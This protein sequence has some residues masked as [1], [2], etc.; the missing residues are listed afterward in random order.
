[1]NDEIA[2]LWRIKFPEILNS[3]TP[4]DDLAA[5]LKAFPA[6][7]PVFLNLA[8]EIS[9]GP[10]PFHSGSVLKH[11]AR[12][13]NETAGDPRAVWLA[14]CHDAGKLL[15]PTAMLPHHYGHETRGARLIPVWSRA[16]GMA[17]EWEKA[18]VFASLWHMR[19]GRFPVLR[20][21]K[22]YRLLAVLDSCSWRQ[23]FW[24]AVNADTRSPMGEYAGECAK[25]IAAWRKAGLSPEKQTELLAKLTASSR[26]LKKRDPA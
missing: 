8:A 5:F 11:V 12:C 26:T 17:P 23:A 20:P 14:F 1:M 2:A 3:A 7:A 21:G 18:G 9:A 22:K 15:T 13:M 19:A 6:G 10:K 24:A 16:L 4:G 25:A